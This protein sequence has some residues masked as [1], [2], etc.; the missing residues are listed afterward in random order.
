MLA[1]PDTP[2][3]V[4]WYKEALGA[5]LLWSLGA[6]AGLELEGAT[7]FLHDP[8]K[9][10]FASPKELGI[11]TV[12]VELFVENPDEVITRAVKAG[13]TDYDIEDYSRALGIH[14]QGGFTDPFGHIWQVGHPSFL[15]H[16]HE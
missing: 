11:T 10:I 1:V 13:A 9:N 12:R 7:F 15:G 5:D 3:A 14:L 4:E 8:V 6:V 2:A 16:F